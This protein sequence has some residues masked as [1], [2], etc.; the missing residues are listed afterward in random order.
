[1]PCLRSIF[2]GPNYEIHKVFRFNHA[3]NGHE[4]MVGSS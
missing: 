3:K 4:E 1:M 2:G